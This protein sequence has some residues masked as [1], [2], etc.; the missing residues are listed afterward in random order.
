MRLSYR[1]TDCV[2]G[3]ATEEGP[4]LIHGI[5]SPMLS[6]NCVFKIIHRG[7]FFSCFVP[8]G[9]MQSVPPPICIAIRAIFVLTY[10]MASSKLLYCDVL[11]PIIIIML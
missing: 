8:P 11:D 9:F 2:Q 7:L 6:A 5:L 4:S 3:G 10:L 1:V